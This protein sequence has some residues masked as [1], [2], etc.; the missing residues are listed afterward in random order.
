MGPDHK[1]EPKGIFDLSKEIF[2][3]PKGIF[4]L[5]KEIISSP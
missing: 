1:R 2:S 5:S 3:F 4:D